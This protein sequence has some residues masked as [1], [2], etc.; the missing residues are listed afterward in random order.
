MDGHFKEK[1]KYFSMQLLNNLES[2]KQVPVV[3]LLSTV[4][5]VWSC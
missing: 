3:D 1:N 5:H 4:P 2:Y